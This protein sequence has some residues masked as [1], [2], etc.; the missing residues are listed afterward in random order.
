MLGLYS[1]EQRCAQHGTGT[2]LSSYRTETVRYV[3]RYCGTEKCGPWGDSGGTQILLSILWYRTVQCVQRYRD[4]NRLHYGIGQL[5]SGN[6]YG[7]GSVIRYWTVRY[8]ST[9]RY[10]VSEGRTALWNSTVEAAGYR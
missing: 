6:G 10:R 4:A 3:C 5:R 8:T 2:V 9:V 1:Q 7:N